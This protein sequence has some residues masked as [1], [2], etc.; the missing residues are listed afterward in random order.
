QFT[1]PDDGRKF[2]ELYN[3]RHLT[4][5]V[6]NPND[7]NRVY[8]STIQRLYSILRDEE[9]EEEQEARS[10]YEA[11]EKGEVPTVPRTISFSG[12]LPISFFDFIVIDECHRSIY[13]V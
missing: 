10:L 12:K 1:T 8:I 5:N 6:I 7:D 11:E 13:T 9:L 4:N 3:I 2:A